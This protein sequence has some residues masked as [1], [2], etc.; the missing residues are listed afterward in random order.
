MN[1]IKELRG[2]MEIAMIGLPAIDRH[3][4]DFM[5]AKLLR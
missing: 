4:Q 5:G 1:A 2:W 3:E